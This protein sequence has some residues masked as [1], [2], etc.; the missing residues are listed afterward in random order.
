MTPTVAGIATQPLSPVLL[1]LP[2]GVPVLLQMQPD[3]KQLVQACDLPRPGRR[4]G[5]RGHGP[6][7][8]RRRRMADEGTPVCGQHPHGD[9]TRTQ[10]APRTQVKAPR[11]VGRQ[12]ARPGGQPPGRRLHLDH[13]GAMPGGDGDPDLQDAPLEPDVQR[14]VDRGRVGRAQRAD[15][16]PHLRPGLGFARLQK[17]KVRLVVGVDPGHQL[18]VGSTH[19]VRVRIG[20][21][22]VPGVS[23]FMISPRPDLLARRD[24]VIGHMDQPRAGHMIVAPGE[25]ARRPHRH[26]GRRHRDVRIPRQVIRPA[27]RDAAPLAAAFAPRLPVHGRKQPR[28]L[29][30][31]D[32]GAAPTGVVDPVV[33]TL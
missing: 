3:E 16:V 10:R 14:R 25:V 29:R 32:P 17:G 19:A 21:I 24:V 8:R 12:R 13:G 6:L 22:A 1:R 33:V 23:K 5:R 7:R 18:H 9:F 31:R 11:P 2:G 30:R 4:R 26:V 20:Q 28:P 27:G 15:R